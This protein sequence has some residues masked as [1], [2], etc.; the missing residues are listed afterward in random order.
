MARYWPAVVLTL[1]L[2]TTGIT[3]VASQLCKMSGGRCV[4]TAG[5][6]A[7][8]SKMCGVVGSAC[9]CRSKQILNKTP[10]PKYETED[11]TAGVI[12]WKRAHRV[13][14]FKQL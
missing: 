5:F 1:V 12:P 11:V 3:D 7:S 10:P 4:D 6:C 8:Q 13:F 9:R 2:L 14:N